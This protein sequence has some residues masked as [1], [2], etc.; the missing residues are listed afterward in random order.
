MRAL[1]YIEFYKLIRQSKVYFALAAIFI[2]EAFIIFSAYF[3]GSDILDVLLNNLKDSFYFEGNLLN[4]NLIVYLILNSLWFHIPLILMIILSG[5]ITAEF[6]DR[7]IQTVLMKPIAKWKFLL[8]KYIVA[9]CF[10][11]IVVVLLAVSSFII[12]YG[13]FGYGDLVVYNSGLNFFETSAAFSRLNAAFATGLMSMIFFSIMSITLG[14]IFKESTKTWIICAFFLILSNILMRIDMGA[15]WLN[16]W[17]FA[18]LNDTWSYWFY[19]DIP[20]QKIYFNVILIGAYS[21]LS[22]ALG[23]YLFQNKDIK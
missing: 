2:I 17:F 8:S 13:I 3:Q 7:T 5:L 10:T 22:L 11:I 15:D 20:W 4:G 12:S 23:L 21:L 14:V 1:I 16:R 18:K 19:Y 6:Q 9:I